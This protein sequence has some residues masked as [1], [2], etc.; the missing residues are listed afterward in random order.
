MK[1]MKK[2]TR[3]KSKIERQLSEYNQ[4]LLQA[5]NKLKFYSCAPSAYAKTEKEI[6]KLKSTIAKLNKK[7][8][9]KAKIKA[10]HKARIEEQREYWASR[11]MRLFGADREKTKKSNMGC[12]YYYGGNGAS[13]VYVIYTPMGVYNK[14]R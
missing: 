11:T 6:E 3:T 10:K 7:Q 5:Y 8:E 2:N 14:R 13:S 9:R 4:Q 1:N 12:P